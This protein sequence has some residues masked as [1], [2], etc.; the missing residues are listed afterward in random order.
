MYRNVTIG[1][2][3]FGAENYAQL[4]EFYGKIETKDQ[5]TLVLTHGDG[6]AKSE[7]GVQ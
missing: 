7:G 1:K 2:T 5:E 3:M 6:A 4:R